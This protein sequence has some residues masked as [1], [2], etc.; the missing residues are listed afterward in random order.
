MTGDYCDF[1]F[2]RRSVDGKYLMR[3][4]GETTFLKFLRRN[5][6]V[7]QDRSSFDT[8]KTIV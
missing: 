5:A 2:L 1:K 8:G 3:F 6:E 7:A 4:T